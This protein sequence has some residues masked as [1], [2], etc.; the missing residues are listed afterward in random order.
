VTVMDVSSLLR[1]G[2]GYVVTASTRQAAW[3]AANITAN[4]KYVSIAQND[5]GNFM[6]IYNNCVTVH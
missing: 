5:S 2:T 3:T 1:R 6:A 4:A